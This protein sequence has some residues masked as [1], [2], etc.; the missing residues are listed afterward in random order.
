[1][2]NNRPSKPD[3][4][5]SRESSGSRDGFAK[6]SNR[7]KDVFSDS[8]SQSSKDNCRN[9]MPNECEQN[10]VERVVECIEPNTLGKISSPLEEEKRAQEAASARVLR[11]PTQDEFDRTHG[12][13]YETY[14]LHLR[15][16][17]YQ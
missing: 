17:F 6:P 1:M 7:E 10:V 11:A 13:N 14:G 5:I 15:K 16:V 12:A 3:F 8:A 2:N 4:R 9:V